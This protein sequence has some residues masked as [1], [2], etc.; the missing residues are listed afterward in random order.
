MFN[1]TG[2]K[3]EVV[4][5]GS[6]TPIK[7]KNFTCKINSSKIEKVEAGSK[8]GREWGEYTR[9]KYEMEITDDKGKGFVG[10]KVW[11][12]FNLDS[13]V[14]SGKAQKTKLELLADS[15]FTIGLEFNNMEEL[16]AANGKFAE[17]YLDVSFSSF[18]GDGDK[19]IQ[20]H[21]LNGV[22]N[23]DSAPKA[24]AF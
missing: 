7:G 5:E 13:D 24:Q 10:R 8:D 21:Y 20:M 9:L 14:R 2:Y 18:K 19:D 6:F 4:E 11:K 12:S 16:E 3:P 17:L 22:F 15:F 1:L 23:A